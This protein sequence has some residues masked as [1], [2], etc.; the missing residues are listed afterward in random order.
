MYN[1]QDINHMTNY[2]SSSINTNIDEYEKIKFSNNSYIFIVNTTKYINMMA[3]HLYME[4][5]IFPYEL[6]IILHTGSCKNIIQLG[7]LFELGLV[8]TINGGFIVRLPFDYTVGHLPMNKIMHHSVYFSIEIK[9]YSIK[10]MKILISTS[11]THITKNLSLTVLYETKKI[12]KSLIKPSYD[13]F[14]N[15]W[16]Y[17][18]PI[19]NDAICNITNETYEYCGGFFINLNSNVISSIKDVKMDVVSASHDSIKYEKISNTLIWIPFVNLFKEQSFVRNPNYNLSTNI[20]F[21]L[22]FDKIQQIDFIAGTFQL[23]TGCTI[24]GNMIG[25]LPSTLYMIQKHKIPYFYDIQI[26]KV[27][28][29]FL[30]IKN[31]KPNKLYTIKFNYSI[32]NYVLDNNFDSIKIAESLKVEPE[33]LYNLKI[34]KLSFVYNSTQKQTELLRMLPNTLEKLTIIIFSKSDR[35]LLDNL[36]S[37]I[38]TIK[39]SGN[40]LIINEKSK[41]PFNAKIIYKK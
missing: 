23:F 40:N 7:F 36:P 29:N 35:I 20:I 37:G 18:I 13:S 17:T 25:Y 15:N 34:K 27:F 26:I 8:L 30:F 19:Q 31:D 12:N 41:I 21:I 14:H 24:R 11:N 1:V 9:N 22:V 10:D 38:L 2:L 6:E 3:S 4:T 16:N 5:T 28:K 33:D 32:Y 39:I